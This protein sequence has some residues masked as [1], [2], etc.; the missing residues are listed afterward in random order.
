MIVFTTILGQT[1]P[2][3][4][5]SRMDKGTRYVCF[6]DQ[7]R[8]YLLNRGW[9]IEQVAPEA[10]P[11][12]QSRRIKI[13]AHKAFPDA[14][15]T[16]WVDA[17]YRLDTLP[18]KLL[19]LLGDSDMVAMR[20]PHRDRITDEA[21]AIVKLGIVPAE[22]VYR[23]LAAYHADGF[24]TDAD[25]QQAIT[26][27]GFFLRRNSERVEEFERAWWAEV[28]RHTYRDQMSIDYVIKKTGV[29]VAYIPGHYRNNPYAKFFLDHR[30]DAA[31]RQ[32]RGARVVRKVDGQAVS[33][34]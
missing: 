12:K 24:D 20:H 28:E 4:R 19:T 2:L 22:D 33:P 27:T 1:D 11:C 25:P 10:D 26:S 21:K 30:S 34:A 18:A 9:H 16:L 8:R 32:A 31:R 6:T 3:R 14:D 17:A 13:M 29:T 7:P 15:V 23:Q 5:P